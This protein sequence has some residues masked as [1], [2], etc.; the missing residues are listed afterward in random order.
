MRAKSR[1]L[2]RNG[3]FARL[4]HRLTTRPGS[5]FIDPMT[6]T[7]FLRRRPLPHEPLHDGKMFSVVLADGVDVGEINET[8]HAGLQIVWA[9]S[10]TAYQTAVRPSNGIAQTQEA[11]MQAFR[12]AWERAEVDLPRHRAH[13]AALDARMA[14]W[15]AKH[16]PGLAT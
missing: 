3:F 11:A 5:G 9:W 14:S 2:N 7:I 16:R 1:P 10:I 15:A 8:T 6:E 13:M 4:P 12:E